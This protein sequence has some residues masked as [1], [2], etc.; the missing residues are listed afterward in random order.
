[1]AVHWDWAAKP[2]LAGDFELMLKRYPQEVGT[3]WTRYC[4]GS[5]A[6]NKRH[7]N[8]YIAHPPQSLNAQTLNK[9]Y[10]AV[11]NDI[12]NNPKHS[13]NFKLNAQ[14]HDSILF[15]HRI[16][17]EYLKDMVVE[18]MQVPVT[19]KAYDG[20]IRTFVVPADASNSGEYWGDIK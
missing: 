17:H 11:F 10:L 13:T 8:A 5:P 14:I 16:G 3:A 18:R 6:S 12:A 1:M 7:K 19:I 2:K 9:S 4:F 20:E 15:Q